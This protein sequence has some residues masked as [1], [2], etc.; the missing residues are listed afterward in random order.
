MVDTSDMSEKE[1]VK[2]AKEMATLSDNQREEIKRAIRSVN[3]KERDKASEIPD[4]D[5]PSFQ[6]P[7]E[8]LEWT[9]QTDYGDK[10]DNSSTIGLED[11]FTAW[12]GIVIPSEYTS[13]E[14][15]R[16]I[17]FTRQVHYDPAYEEL[18]KEYIILGAGMDGMDDYTGFE[19]AVEG[20]KK[21]IQGF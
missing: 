20:F 3:Q 17:K 9:K 1:I 11:G 12:Q 18:T 21:A 14:T 5:G 8:E 13:P 10:L 6:V 4:M 19:N 2:K 16:D 7:V 15:N